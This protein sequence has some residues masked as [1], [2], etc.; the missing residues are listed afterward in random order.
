MSIFDR[1]PPPFLRRETSIVY[2][3]DI[4]DVY[5]RVLD[6]VKKE[7]S[8]IIESTPPTLIRV[9]HQPYGV[10]HKAYKKEIEVK[11]LQIKTD[12]IVDFT[13]VRTVDY[14]VNT[15]TMVFWGLFEDFF[16]YIGAQV[17]KEM[18]RRLYPLNKMNRSIQ[19]N[20]ALI[21]IFGFFSLTALVIFLDLELF[22]GVLSA[23]AVSFPALIGIKEIR[24]LLK[25]KKEL[26]TEEKGTNYQ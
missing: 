3:A 5:S 14:D 21:L 18:R 16:S 24:R 26:Y 2:G 8:T 13:V 7:K 4:E 20:W 1:E 15:P 11:L 22:I 9:I 12:I 19:F 25:L 23:I 10:D 6:W 17:T